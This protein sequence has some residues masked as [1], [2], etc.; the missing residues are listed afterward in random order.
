MEL[1]TKAYRHKVKEWMLPAGYVNSISKETLFKNF[2]PLFFNMVGYNINFQWVRESESE[3]VV[4]VV[5]IR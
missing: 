4:L 1:D 2:K 5:Q 3:R